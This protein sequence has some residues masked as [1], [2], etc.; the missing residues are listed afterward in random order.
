MRSILILIF[1]TYSGLNAQTVSQLSPDLDVY[2][3]VRDFCISPQGDE[4][5]F[6][7]QSPNQDISQIVCVKN[8]D[9]KHP[10]L[11][12]FC[13]G[14]AY[15]EPFL[16]PDG[17][18]LLFASNRPKSDTSQQSGD[19]DI[20]YVNRKS[21]KDEWSA[22]VNVGLPVNTTEDEFYPVI[23]QNQN[24]YLTK[25]SKTG[26][27]KDDI[28]ICQWNGHTYEAPALLSTEVN[29]EGYEFN[30]YVSP[31][32]SFIIFT[33][34]NAKGGYGSGDLYI[35]RKNAHG[36]WTAAENMGPEINS[37]FMEYC[38]YYDVNSQTLY[39]T[40]KRNSLKP[41]KFPDLSAYID[42]ISGG[43]NGLSKIYQYNIKL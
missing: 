32:E 4:A 18:K 16:S 30:A 36:N 42:Y 35:A 33:R 31:D 21:P 25:D 22:P 40:S 38:P 6:T 24:L 7:I 17:L 29:S 13:D 11:L 20:W 41:K 8:K 43:E 10:Q 9:W 19:Y 5:Y 15:L 3:N 12:A 27:G 28:Y 2:Q 1:F 37:P 23:T 39:F 14:H 34:Y 26:M